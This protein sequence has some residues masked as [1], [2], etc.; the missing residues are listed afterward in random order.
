[1]KSRL[2]PHPAALAGIASLWMISSASAAIIS[3]YPLEEGT[4]TSTDQ[5]IGGGA[6]DG[7]LVGASTI[8]VPGI[9]PGSD[10]ALSF[11][12]GS[13]VEVAGNTLW[14]GLSG[15]S[16]SAWIQPSSYAGSGT[17]A[18]PIFWLGTSGG[19][20]RF[21]I[22]L[23]DFG[24]LRVGGR[25]AGTEGDFNGSLV[26][27]TNVGATNGSDNDP[28]APG[29]T[30]HVA[31]TAD[32]STGLL[33][34]YLNGSLVASNTIAAWGTGVSASDQN[35]VIRIGSNHNGGEQ[36]L[37]IIDDVRIFNTALSSSEVG[38]LAVP[39]PSVALLGGLGLMGFLRR[40]HRA[41]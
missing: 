2:L 18:R 4:G 27:G 8:W 22:Q 40:R 15:F 3:H 1:M 38:A 21:T 23:N 19:S 13:R 32:Y 5:T 20:A 36:F 16:V 34:L 12:S 28:I 33:S 14:H 9:A 39:E 31:A 17:S 35:Y 25:R 29:E 7:S 24:D 11:S 41:G 30:Y 26:V 10:S 37:G 6:P